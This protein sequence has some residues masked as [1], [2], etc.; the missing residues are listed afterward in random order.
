[1]S[2]LL[3]PR[4]ISILRSMYSNV[5]KW[6]YTRELAKL[7]KVSSWSVSRQ[8]SKL[9]RE[10]MV[11]ERLEGREKFYSLNLS[12]VRSRKICEFF[13]AEKRE[14]F[15][16]KNR[17]FAWVLEDFTKKAAD[18]IPET[19]S[20][21]LFGSVARGEAT[22]RSDVDILVLVPNYEEERFKKVMSSVDQLASEVSGRHPARLVPVVMMM[23]DY[24]QG[25]KDKKRFATDILKDRIILF[26]EERYYYL[27][28]KV[29]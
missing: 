1:M 9:V 14:D 2:E 29:V 8:F 10:G 22:S 11:K 20:V 13:E 5:E 25:L 15:L 18:F 12:N 23:R 3:T 19:Q 4:V 24:E 16:K 28:S 26:G 7:A 17:R 6:Y 27:L 21:V